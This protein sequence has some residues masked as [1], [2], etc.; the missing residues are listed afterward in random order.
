[1]IAPPILF[2]KS[3]HPRIGIVRKLKGI[4]EV[5]RLADSNDMRIRIAPT[6]LRC[7]FEARRLDYGRLTDEPQ[8]TVEERPFKGRVK[9]GLRMGFSPRVPSSFGIPRCHPDH[10]NQPARRTEHQPDNADPIL[11]QPAVEKRPDQIPGHGPGRKHKRKLAIASE[12]N[13]RALLLV[14][15]LIRRHVQE[16][17]YAGWQVESATA[18]LQTDELSS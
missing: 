11:M 5:E 6:R 9:M 10:L 3:D 1:M 14:G 17:F 4:Y 15:V 13:P 16:R 2:E 7:K 18:H 8:S 12:L